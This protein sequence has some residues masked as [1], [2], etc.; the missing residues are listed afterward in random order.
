MWVDYSTETPSSMILFFVGVSIVDYLYLLL[1]ERKT[2]NTQLSISLLLFDNDS[3]NLKGNPA[4]K[5]FI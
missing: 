4:L 1:P 3:F 5:T 2:H